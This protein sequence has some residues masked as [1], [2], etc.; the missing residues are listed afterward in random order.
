MNRSQST[1]IV[2]CPACRNDFAPQASTTIPYDCYQC[3]SKVVGAY[4]DL[5]LIGT[6]SMGAVYKARRPDMRDQQVAIKIP[7]TSDEQFRKRFEREIA[8][9]AMLRHENI[10]RAFDC[11][12]VDGR[13]FLA[14]ELEDGKLLADLV[15]LDHPL[16]CQLIGNVI[17]DVASGISHANSHGIVN[18]DIKP[19]NILVNPDGRSKILDFGLATIRDLDGGA[20]RV[21]GPGVR[22]GTAAFMAPEQA[23]EPRDVTAAADIYSLG[24]TAYFALVGRPPF[25][26]RLAAIA[27]QHS[28]APRPVIQF[29]RP[30]VP[31][32]LEGLIHRMMAIDPEERPTAEA[33]LAELL[34][35]LPTLPWD[36]SGVAIA[37]GELI[38]DDEPASDDDSD[39]LQT[40]AD[41]EAIPSRVIPLDEDVPTGEP[42][43]DST[44]DAT[45]PLGGATASEEQV[46]T[47]TLDD[48]ITGRDDRATPTATT[49]S[50]TVPLTKR[51][52][53][54]TPP[55]ARAN[56]AGVSTAAASTAAANT[57]QPTDAP[58]A[59]AQRPGRR[60]PRPNATG[61]QHRNRFLVFV[62]GCALLMLAV[63]F[64]VSPFLGPPDPSVVWNE[65]QEEYQ[66]HKWKLVETELA[67]FEIDYPEHAGVA[68]IPFFLAMCEAGREVFSQTGDM[69]DGLGKIDRIF[70]EFRDSP[71]YEKYCADLFQNLQRLIERLVEHTDKASSPNSLASAKKAHELLRTVAQSMPDDWVPAKVSDLAKEIRRADKTLEI[72]LA[73]QRV[74]ELLADSSGEEVDY[75]KLDAG[76]EQT[77]AVLARYPSLTADGAIR[78]ALQDA[79][80]AESA[81]VSYEP[82]DE[83]DDDTGGATQ[84]DVDETIFVVWDEPSAATTTTGMSVYL[85]LADGI[86]Y[87]FDQSGN[88]LWSHRLGIDSDRLPLTL[89]PT[90]TS[91][92]AVIAVSS[93]DNSLVAI[94]SKTGQ[95]L[96][97]Y[98]PGD[99]NALTASLTLSRWRPAPNKPPR[100]RGLI[101]TES[102]EV[103]V[104]ELV[105]G[106][107]MGRFKM[108]VPM[109]VGGAFD[110]AT[111][112][113]YFPA[114]SK[115]VFALDPAVIEARKKTGQA[116]R[117][118]LFTDHL[119]GSLR[120]PPVVVGQYMLLTELLDLENTQVRAF[121]LLA[122][123][124]FFK[125][126]AQPVSERRL[127]GW[128]WFTSPI[129]PDRITIVTDS[130]ELGVLGLNLDNREEAL[131]PL[132]HDGT[133]KPPSLSISVPYRALAIHSDEH[134][135]WVMAGGTL[136]QIALDVLA[137]KTHT[138][139]PESEDDAQVVGLPLHDATFD[140]EAERIYV[141]TRSLDAT[142]AQFTSVDANSGQRL[143]SRQLGIHPVGEALASA[144]V[145]L[146]IDQSGRTLQMV[147][148][149][150]Q[151]GESR[152]TTIT[153]DAPLGQQASGQLM[154]LVDL[155]GQE[156]L[157]LPLDDGRSIAVRAIGADRPLQP[158]WQKI[159]V[160][161]ARLQGRPAVLEG[162]LIAPCSNGR[163]YR[164]PLAGSP[165]GPRNEQTFPWTLESSLA[166][167]DYA[168]VYPLASNQVALVLRDSIRWL[169]YRIDDAVGQWHELAEALTPIP[170]DG[171]LVVAQDY[172]FVPAG[173]RSMFRLPRGGS[174][175]DP[176][177]WRLEGSRTDGP[178]VI[179][180]MVFVVLGGRKLVA[181]SP[182]DSQPVWSAGPF[183]GRIRG[184][185][186]RILGGLL[187]TDDSGVISALRVDSGEVVRE[188]HLQPGAVP[189]GAATRLGK[190]LIV[191]LADGSIASHLPR[192]QDGARRP[193]AKR[194]APT[195]TTGGSE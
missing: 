191:P 153:D 128:S 123:N 117:S 25:R 93:V 192:Q 137:Q 46:A 52:S 142:H 73:K 11:G 80:A 168:S 124:G 151:T 10:V 133:G 53:L 143:W 69:T 31:D 77:N 171:E 194:T 35:F 193:A 106:K 186:T 90:A 39:E 45:V 5:E 104:L 13:P 99:E 105:R 7:K 36:T 64:A 87:A 17:R 175:D 169:E 108:N 84:E 156:Y 6:G 50:A 92:D 181:F 115:R 116:V 140:R 121:E 95:V 109:T 81:R 63:W 148:Q 51:A 103:H 79:Y 83:Q 100:V 98:Y 96:W 161:A 49:G 179:G 152:I 107:R 68:E 178:F 189:V 180:D 70:V 60:Q 2:E 138:L 170:T 164:I 59:T 122:P 16:P 132:I 113:A 14:M 155:D 22:L 162:Y 125:P 12:E 76:Y 129:T 55:T 57:A 30:D 54:A 74:L 110:S 18:R 82:F 38:E 44:D 32:A 183:R 126:D 130:G 97:R 67:Q 85:A 15:R 111:Q 139:W 4:C 66:L 102:G 182:D 160:P 149:T 163:L 78:Q 23:R 184:R 75:R 195:T 134:L 62:A 154:R 145:A 72:V 172:L 56:T 135:L 42:L 165:A 71:E 101:P 119:S 190:R 34:S 94:A 127:R 9:S 136:R 24:C 131:Y 150:S 144:G 47:P 65:I 177:E 158:P 185:P 173:K 21:T 114:D 187:V 89:E 91:P 61:R 20:D 146:L 19:E 3:S 88:H 147:E 118:V 166:A 120:S 157:A 41:G 37:E 8:A 188:F 58:T 43:D 174:T 48:I 40:V 28:E 27:R 29:A 1:S 167:D 176:A 26:G 86:L 159:S 141:T 33:V 112:L